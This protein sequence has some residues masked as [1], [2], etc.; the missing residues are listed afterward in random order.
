MRTEKVLLNQL[1]ENTAVMNVS[2]DLS[3][4]FNVQSEEYIKGFHKVYCC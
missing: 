3:Y 4:Y 2:N 1:Y